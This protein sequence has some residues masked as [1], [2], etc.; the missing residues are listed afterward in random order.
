MSEV[1]KR[2]RSD[3]HEQNINVREV[4]SR[5]S[6]DYSLEDE[7]FRYDPTKEYNKRVVT[8]KMDQECQFCDTKKF[9][10]ATA[11]M[12]CM[13]GKILLAPLEVPPE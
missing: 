9:S 6:R 11:G 1:R 4:R 3:V 8:D 10:T 5:R 7:A 2:L 12:C 13:S